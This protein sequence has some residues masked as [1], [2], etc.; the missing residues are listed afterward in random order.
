M[1]RTA[2]AKRKNGSFRTVNDENF[3]IEIHQKR[4]IS[5]TNS[6]IYSRKWEL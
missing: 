4:D 3:V 5:K 6:I 1:Q 2:L